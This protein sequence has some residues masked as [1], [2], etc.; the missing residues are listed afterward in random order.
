[1]G[2]EMHTDESRR[3]I[4]AGIY[5]TTQLVNMYTLLIDRCKLGPAIDW[6]RGSELRVGT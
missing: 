6:C 2:E 5:I 3:P 4:I 1:M